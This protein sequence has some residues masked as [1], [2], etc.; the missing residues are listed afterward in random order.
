MSYAKV[1]NELSTGEPAAASAAN[2]IDRISRYVNRASGPLIMATMLVAVYGVVMRY[3]FNNPI[4]WGIEISGFLLLGAI[5]AALAYT[6]QIDGH[7]S[8]DYGLSKMSPRKR[9]LSESVAALLALFFCVMFAEQCWLYFGSSVSAGWH[10]SGA[11]P[12]I[13]W[14][15]TLAMSLGASCLAL[16][17]VVVLLKLIGRLRNGPR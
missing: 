2:L 11:I 12:F 5:F 17:Y 14:P 10:T 4:S 1:E 16:Q 6:L 15:T 3:V 9:L 8:V 13:I 7:V